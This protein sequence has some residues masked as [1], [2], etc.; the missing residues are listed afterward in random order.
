MKHSWL[1]VSVYKIYIATY[2]CKYIDGSRWG[3]AL[4]S[5]EY[6]KLEKEKKKERERNSCTT[7][8]YI[9]FLCLCPK[10]PNPLPSWK[11]PEY[12]T[13][14]L[15][16]Y[17]VFVTLHSWPNLNTTA[18]SFFIFSF[19]KLKMNINA[20]KK[21][22]IYLIKYINIYSIIFKMSFWIST[23]RFDLNQR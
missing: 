12:A 6:K 19:F 22:I 10:D 21:K 5:T 3:V 20:I 4:P 17:D 11:I 9:W 2:V 7:Y 23:V 16:A 1:H 14:Y 13:A 15:Y 18:T 8:I